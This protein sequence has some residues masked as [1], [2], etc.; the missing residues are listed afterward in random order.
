MKAIHD[1][2]PLPLR[3]RKTAALF[4][5]WSLERKGGKEDLNFLPTKHRA[6]LEPQP[7]TL[8]SLAASPFP[9]QFCQQECSYLA[10]RSLFMFYLYSFYLPGASHML[11]KNQDQNPGLTVVRSALFP[12][13]H[14]VSTCTALCLLFLTFTLNAEFLFSWVVSIHSHTALIP[15]VYYM[16]HE[17]VL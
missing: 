14:T 4:F 7:S 3:H 17:Y 13:A 5:S 6:T 8:L 2:L 1:L 12:R 9:R 16:L 15:Q 10:P 11:R